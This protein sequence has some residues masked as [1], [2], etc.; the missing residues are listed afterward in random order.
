MTDDVAAVARSNLEEP[1]MLCVV[2]RCQI[3]EG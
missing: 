2:D 1:L 3:G